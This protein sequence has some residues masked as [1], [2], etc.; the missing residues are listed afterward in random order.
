MHKENQRQKLVDDF[1]NN[2]SV[3]W[4]NYTH[5]TNVYGEVY[6][7]RQS[8]A[9]NY[10][11]HLPISKNAKIL[12]IGCGAGQL[13]INLAEKGFF[14]E[15]IDNA[16]KM[17]EV[18]RQ[19]V[20]KAKLEKTVHLKVAD[21]HALSFEENS[22]DVVVGMGVVIWLHNLKKA[23]SEIHR[24]L[25]P[26]GFLILSLDNRYAAHIL[27]DLPIATKSIMKQRLNRGGFWTQK[28]D[29]DA[30]NPRFFS[31]KEFNK[32]LGEFKFMNLRRKYLGFGPFTFFGR[33]IFSGKVGVIVSRQMQKTAD[34]GFSVLQ[35][36]GSQCVVLATKECKR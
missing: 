30:L 13:T 28:T 25:K 21:V 7:E 34:N 23:L 8:A 2:T 10:I 36:V 24:V 4:K 6:R 35:L 14:V 15:A 31:E 9:M 32:I 12:E 33:E 22:F 5:L 3:F 29:F 18:C 20:A 16:P 27:F 1:F 26:G 19:S 11:T 17:V